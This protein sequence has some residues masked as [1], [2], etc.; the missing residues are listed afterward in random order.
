SQ[1]PE[2]LGLQVRTTVPCRKLLSCA[3]SSSVPGSIRACSII[4]KCHNSASNFC[5][6]SLIPFAAKDLWYL[7]AQFLFFYFLFNLPYLAAHV[8][9]PCKGSAQGAQV[10]LLIVEV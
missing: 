2:L 5:E 9:W 4:S 3:S 6:F 8:P 1:P 10:H 7:L